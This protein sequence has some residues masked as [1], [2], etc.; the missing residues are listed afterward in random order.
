MLAK[1]TRDVREIKSIFLQVPEVVTRRG[2]RNPN[3][4]ICS[5]TERLYF[6]P[7][8]YQ[9]LFA[10]IKPPMTL[11]FPTVSLVLFLSLKPFEE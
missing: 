8:N 10:L 4:L 2:D 11:Q 7:K 1:Y 3:L 6:S 5:F 9:V